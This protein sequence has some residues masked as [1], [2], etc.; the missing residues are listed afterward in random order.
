MAY[1]HEQ[2]TEELLKISLTKF[3]GPEANEVGNYCIVGHNYRNTKFF[4]KIS[5]LEIGDIIE[6]TDLSGK[7]IKYKVYDQY[8]VEPTDVECTSQ[9]TNGR[10]EVTLI[11]CTTDSKHRTII[12][13]T[14]VK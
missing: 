6:I 8:V 3:W 5:T 2:E 11:T 10:R 14:E 1:K 9:H 4:S 7:T 12:K 13:A